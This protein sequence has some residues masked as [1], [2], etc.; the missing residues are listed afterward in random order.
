[1][2]HIEIIDLT[3]SRDSSPLPY[4]SS[5][6]VPMILNIG[7]VSTNPNLHNHTHHHQH[8]TNVWVSPPQGL[9]V[10]PQSEIN[11]N[12][13]QIANMPQLGIQS[14]S[15]VARVL[16]PL[17][18]P[19]TFPLPNGSRLRVPWS[20]EEHDLFV[21]GLIEYG[22]GKWSKIAKHYVCS[23]TPQQVQY[24]AR[25]FFKYL[26]ASYVHG[27]RRKKLSSNSNNFA[28][29]RNKETLNLFPMQD[30]RGE[31]STSMTVPRVSAAG[32]GEVDVELR[33]SLYK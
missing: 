8:Q 29:R 27:F 28:S 7:H 18:E 16:Q 22:K 6:N 5:S 32:N 14:G 13:S 20:Q 19:N 11:N 24:Y 25:S 23:K 15:P 10:S 2:S 1:M 21:M 4:I 30:S 3:N 9:R 33:L 17:P 26:P 31:S 12:T